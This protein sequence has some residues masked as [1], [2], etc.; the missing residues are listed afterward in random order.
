[1]LLFYSFLVYG[2]LGLDGL[3]GCAEFAGARKRQPGTEF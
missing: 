3:N 2:F 1:L